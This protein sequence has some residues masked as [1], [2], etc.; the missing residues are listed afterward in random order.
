MYDKL[1]L[2]LYI[3]YINK[4]ILYALI[5]CAWKEQFCWNISK[6]S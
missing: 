1:M 5:L 6:F 3:I 2:F 4:T